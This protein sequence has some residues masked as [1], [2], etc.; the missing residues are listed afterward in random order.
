MGVSVDHL[1]GVLLEVTLSG[2]VLLSLVSLAMFGCRQPA[3]R[4][5][6]AR[7]SILC[8]L[9]VLP[10][11]ALLPRPRIPLI[12]VLERTS[13]ASHP[14]WHVPSAADAEPPRSPDPLVRHIPTP[15]TELDQIFG[16]RAEQARWILA[17]YLVMVSLA[18]SWLL[19]GYWGVGWLR[20]KSWEPSQASLDV[21]RALP[22]FGRRTRPNLRVA[23]RIRRPVL[24]GLFRQTILIP[25]ALD[26]P[27]AEESLRLTLLHE[28][29]HSDRRDP[30]FSLASGLAHSVWF[31]LPP[32]WWIRAQMRLDQEFLADHEASFGFGPPRA[33]A[34]SLLNLASPSPSPRPRA[35][36]EAVKLSTS[37]G[38]VP[39]SALFQ[40][41]LM[42]VHC[43]FLIETH[44]PR[45]WGLT[46]ISLI[47]IGSLGLSSISV[48]DPSEVARTRTVTPT[49][50]SVGK[51][52][53]LSK[54]TV[55]PTKAQP[56]HKGELFEFPFQLPHHFL[57]D[58]DVWGHNDSLRQTRLVGIKLSLPA[59]HP[60]Y[61][62]PFAAWHH[63]RIRKLDGK[64]I[65][66]I[67]GHPVPVD[68][69]DRTTFWLSV[70]S[71]LNWTASFENLILHW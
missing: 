18:L 25:V 40:R 2:T 43:P 4:I 20:S 21:Y 61:G 67:D 35:A 56:G 34:A 14:L 3:R 9:L 31:F 41:V 13:L 54:L 45:W 63:V 22:S 8:V 23:Y 28:L 51:T 29:A 50:A 48:F 42:L 70:E 62:H 59:Q 57:L 12:R 71:P 47:L 1:G 37:S 26:A 16:K 19:F 5:V 33:Y 65:V 7:A 24:L 38:P 49:P 10:M 15:T 30:W 39:N 69:K 44:P 46:L 60:A 68:P 53:H 64:L 32:M 58:L 17:A 6:L 11:A 66:W 55:S 27:G 36:N 52:F